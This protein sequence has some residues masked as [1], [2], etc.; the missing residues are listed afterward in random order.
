[1]AGHSINLGHHIQFQNTSILFAKSRYMDCNIREANKTE[2]Y[3][4]HMNRKMVSA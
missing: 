4:K 1:M 3:P 2:L